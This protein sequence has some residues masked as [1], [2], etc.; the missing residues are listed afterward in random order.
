MSIVTV[1]YKSG[2]K[3][4]I[5]CQSFEVEKRGGELWRVIW[6]SP[7]PKPLFFGIDDVAAIYE[8]KA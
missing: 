2:V 8:G 5:E 3:I 7:E 1:I 4:Q 6:D